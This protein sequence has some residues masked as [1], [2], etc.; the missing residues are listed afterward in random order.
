MID[1]RRLGRRRLDLTGQRLWFAVQTKI[2]HLHNLL[3]ERQPLG[4]FTLGVYYER[5][6]IEHQF[7][8]PPHQ[9]GID[10]GQSVVTGTLLDQFLP[11]R[12][13]AGVERR[14]IQIEQQLGTCLARHGGR[15][16]QPDILADAQSD[17]DSLQL[18]ADR[19][20]TCSEIAL[21]I[22]NTVIRQ[23]LLAIFGK[24]LAI[25]DDA[26]HV[27]QFAPFPAWVTDYQMDTPHRAANLLQ[28]PLYTSDKIIS[29]QQIFR[30]ITGQCQFWEKDG[31]G[32]GKLRCLDDP[33]RIALDVTYQKIELGNLNGQVHGGLMRLGVRCY[34]FKNLMRTK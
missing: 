16:R 33:A 25:P 29:Q 2:D 18:K 5:A 10:D 4:Q 32:S 13:L 27:V 14:G 26:C 12:G 15:L 21:F 7:I 23:P 22:E 11:F 34:Y 8:L 3:I 28:G 19:Y 6:T 24:D 9:I 1:R 20:I 30:R 31:M 17:P